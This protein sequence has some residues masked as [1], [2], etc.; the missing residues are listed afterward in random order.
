MKPMRLRSALWLVGAAPLLPSLIGS[1]VNIWYNLTHI[2]PLLTP[3]QRDVFVKTTVLYN[4]TAYPLLVAVWVRI[5]TSLR[6]PIMRV[7]LGLPVE[8][9]RLGRARRRVINLPWWSVVLAGSGW[10]LCIPVFLFTLSRTADQLDPR[11]YIHMP[12]SF[13]I[14]GMIAVTHGFFILELLSQR[15]LYPF[16]FADARPW[17]TR[18]ALALSLRARGLLWA[19]SAGV[20]PIASLL[21]LTIIPTT[22]STPSFALA[23]GGLGIAFGLTTAWLVGRLVTEPVNELRRAAQAVGHGN[24]EVQIAQRRADDFGPLIDEFNA[25][26]GGLREKTRIEETLGRHVGRQIA[27]QILERDESLGGVEQE[28]TVMFVDIRN[29]TARAAAST[30]TQVVSVLNLFLTE[31]VEIVEQGHGGIVNKF[32]GDGLM[33]LFSEWTGRADHADAAVDAGQ[34]MLTRLGQIN[35]EVAALGQL[36]L[37]IGIGI[38]TGP[39]VVGSIGSPRRL[40]YTAIGDTVNLAAR[41]ES[42][43]KDYHASI[44]ISEFTHEYVKDRF[45]M[46]ALGDVTVKGKTVPVKIYAVLPPDIRKYPRAVLDAGAILTDAATGQVCHVRTLD[47]GEGGL[48]LAGVPAEW[49]VG[50]KIQIRL[51]GGQLSKPLTAEG[52]IAWRRGDDAGINF[53]QVESDSVVEYV[54]SLR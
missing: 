5:L 34:E 24:L 20:C 9:E 35:V 53:T 25:M 13:A 16:F 40:E 27:R 52:T 51:E 32:L 41:L 18:G 8:P 37:A 11:L 48:A 49:K 19:I 39:A 44:I 30:P 31:M 15:L 45:P 3:L 22:S 42:I 43:T 14:S 29:F 21:L 23:V 1:A 47:I 4:L 46:R 28:I 50:N 26:V 54:A 12:V 2:D 17:E 36:P 6:A 33:A 38:H 7:R 10:F